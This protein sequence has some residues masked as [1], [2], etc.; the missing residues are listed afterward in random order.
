M[1]Q[2][3]TSMQASPTHVDLSAGALNSKAVI[4]LINQ[5]F[6]DRPAQD[7][8]FKLRRDTFDD[9]RKQ[10]PTGIPVSPDEAKRINDFVGKSWGV[11]DYLM[12]E[13]CACSH[14]GRTL[15]FYDFFQGGRERHGDEFVM[16]W[17]VKS[18]PV[19][20]I[21]KSA[22]AE[23]ACTACGTTNLISAGYDGPEY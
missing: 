7:I 4:E 10:L 14:C 23:V 16:K 18:G 11:D 17:L 13:K 9:Y 22:D 6:A 12:R 3:S 2:S 1:T 8:L 5:H 21:R 20:H 15:T 19:V